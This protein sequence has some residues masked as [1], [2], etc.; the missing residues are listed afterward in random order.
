MEKVTKQM[1]INEILRFNRILVQQK[2]DSEDDKNIKKLIAENLAMI[3][4]IELD[5]IERRE[6]RRSRKRAVHLQ[7][8]V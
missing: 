8:C 6:E 4:K 7:I 3:S 5:E 2:Y 1:C